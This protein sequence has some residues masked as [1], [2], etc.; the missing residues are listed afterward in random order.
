MKEDEF[1]LEH[2]CKAFMEAKKSFVETSTSES[3]DKPELEMDPLYANNFPRNL[4]EV[5]T[6]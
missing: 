3:K 1:D 5:T 2:T 6:R 4:Y